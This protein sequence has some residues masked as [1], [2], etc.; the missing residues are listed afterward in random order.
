[1]FCLDE[2]RIRKSRSNDVILYSLFVALTIIHEHRGRIDQ[3]IQRLMTRMHGKADVIICFAKSSHLMYFECGSVLF[4]ITNKLYANKCLRS[5]PTIHPCYRSSAIQLNSSKYEKI[6]L[7]RWHPHCNHHPYSL[8]S[9]NPPFLSSANISI[10]EPSHPPNNGVKGLCE[11]ELTPSFA[12]FV[13]G[14]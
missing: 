13:M 10:I 8:S 14:R 11:N 6:C 3:C 12:R 4:L 9:F 7:D 1:M 5:L 2:E